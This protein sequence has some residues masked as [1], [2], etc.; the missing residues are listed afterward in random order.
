MKKIV[1][2]TVN[3]AVDISTHA[4]RVI[5]VRK[6]RCGKAQREPGGGGI[7]VARVLKRLG[8]EVTALFTAGGSTGDMLGRLVASEGV[9]SVLL[10]IDGETRENFTVNET[11]GLTQF[12]FVLAGPTLTTAEWQCS[13][14]LLAEHISAGDFLV[15]SGSL[16]EGVPTS[17]YTSVAKIAAETGASFI[18]DTAGA[19]LAGALGPGVSLVKPNSREL[20][21]LIGGDT[22]TESAQIEACRALVNAEK[23][24]AVALT[25]GAEG[26][27]LV[28]DNGVWRGRPPKVATSSAVGAG[29]S[30]TA[31]MVWGMAAGWQIEK[32]F[33][34][35]IAAGAATALTPGTELCHPDDVWRFADQIHLERIT[36]H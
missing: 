25:L 8:A 12:R 31:G 7:N 29:D 35:G 4:E 34:L 17:F 6:L 14:A 26:A 19:A 22:A 3:P 23:A 21:D 11:E 5:P 20:A 32:A 9:R 27:L 2:L 16:P 30:F 1:T 24:A 13:L 36:D 18:L 15:A 28:T 10:P 33:S